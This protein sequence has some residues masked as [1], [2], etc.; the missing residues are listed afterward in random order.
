[1]TWP[2][3]RT[4]STNVTFLGRVTLSAVVGEE[5]CPSHPAW[6][7]AGL[8]LEFDV[9]EAGGGRSVAIAFPTID[10]VMAALRDLDQERHTE[11]TVGDDTGAYVTVGGGCG[12]YH[13][14][15]GADD[16]DD[17]VVLQRPVSTGS[18]SEPADVVMDGRLQRF[19]ARDIVDLDS[20]VEVVAEFIRTGRPSLD[21]PWRRA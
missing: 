5:G 16:H 18:G 3:P 14:Y 4:S 19:A 12:F 9:R 20:A 11:V 10:H 17:R 1:M 15:M 8:W 7:R 2:H 6:Q 13:V 21:L